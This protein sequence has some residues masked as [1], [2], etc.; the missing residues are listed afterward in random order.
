[1]AQEIS[2]AFRSLIQAGIPSAQTS[3]A[4]GDHLRAWE[5]VQGTPWIVGISI[6]AQSVLG[7][8]DAVWTQ[9]TAVNIGVAL[10]VL[11]LLFGLWRR[12]APRL[13]V[14][15][16][17]ANEWA[18]GNW[19]HRAGVRGRDELA[20]LA[21]TFNSMAGELAR[22]DA[23]ITRAK[24]DLE[25]RVIDRTRLLQRTRDD[26]EQ[27][28]AERLHADALLR[29]SEE[30]YRTIVETAQE[31]VW[32]LDPDARTVFVNQSMADML[33]Y[34]V[35]DVLGQQV[36]TFISVEEWPLAEASLARG[37]AGQAERLDFRFKR[38]DGSDLWGIV[39]C[40]PTFD[41]A[42]N[43]TGALA[44]VADITER[45]RNVQRLQVGERQLQEAE[46]IA[47]LGHWVWEIEEDRLIWSDEHYRILGL[48]PQSIHVS[49]E[50]G[51]AFVHPD[52]RAAIRAEFERSLRE[53]RSYEME[54]RIVRP[55]G[56]VAIVES[57]G[58]PQIDES[59]KVAR[60]MGTAQD[61]TERRQSE[62][63][64]RQA[65]R[66]EAIGI[67]AGGVAHDFNNLL[68]AIIGFSDLTMDRLD[69]KDPLRSF[70]HEISA[71]GQRAAGLT[72][73]LLAFSRK[74]NLE[75]KVLSL[76]TLVGDMEKLLRRVIG[77]DVILVTELTPDLEPVE[78]DPG[79]IEQVIMNLAVNA[80]DAM[81]AGGTLT[82]RTE[83]ATLDERFVR[84]HPGATP[85][86]SVRLTVTDTGTGMD[87][88]TQ[89]RIFE[90]FFTTKELG[91]GTGLGLSTV[92]G[93][94][95]QS[96]GSIWVTSALGKGT[97]FE[98]VLPRAQRLA[99]DAA[100]QN[101]GQ[102]LPGGTETV[103]VVEDEEAVRTLATTVLRSLGYTVLTAEDGNDALVVLEAADRQ[104]DL[105]LTD[106]VMPSMGGVELGDEVQRRY[107]NLPV[108]YMTGFELDGRMGQR[109]VPEGTPLLRKPFAPRALAEWVRK[110]LDGSRQGELVVG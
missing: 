56:T 55:D 25:S 73:Q 15:E 58:T 7:P 33:G 38:K 96:G 70:V 29:D 89:E 30:R 51:I 1:V 59:G 10:A 78:V 77:E 86:R 18:R 53:R 11:S 97:T 3:D 2:P 82:I 63:A 105:L 39:S 65:Q 106:L 62:E 87:S 72:R 42:G 109:A 85:G 5:A 54:L 61:I 41:P 71:A 100:E 91:R 36:F 8:I 20:Q 92:Y 17:A 44:M 75:P 79:Q 22:R 88:E 80:R 81:P 52:D 50:D 21:T 93:I 90:P 37:R 32:I 13:A 101:S 6:P 31:G 108:L 60:M 67:L 107:P 43:Y 84:Q 68:T 19:E 74:Q 14:L 66:M 110:G 57:R 26:L 28:L 104:V 49:L 103:V 48:E 47:H 99:D 94:V 69:E 98:I 95:K 4:D 45:R 46:A 12:H 23:E 102:G 35:D 83:G 16:R 64:F 27:E 24:L 9:R 76:N 34:A 40:S